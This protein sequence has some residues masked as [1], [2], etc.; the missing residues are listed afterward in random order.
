[1]TL[2]RHRD[3]GQAE[4]NLQQDHVNHSDV[5]FYGESDA[6][7]E[8]SFQSDDDY[9]QRVSSEDTRALSPGPGN[10]IRE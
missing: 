3:T 4:H 10:G 6:V 9:Y 7:A 2:H 5:I 8:D 1:M